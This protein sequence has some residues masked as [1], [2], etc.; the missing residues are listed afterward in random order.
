[1]R[2]PH[3]AHLG[4]LADHRGKLRHGRGFHDPARPESEVATVVASHRPR[5]YQGRMRRSTHE[6]VHIVATAT[7]RS[8]TWSQRTTAVVIPWA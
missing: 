1:V 7:S 2:G 3:G 8:S 6:L 5:R 4:G